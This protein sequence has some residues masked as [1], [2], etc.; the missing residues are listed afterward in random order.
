MH[1]FAF[2]RGINVG[3][4]KII[5]MERLREVLTELGLSDVQTYIQSGNVSFTTNQEDAAQLSTA[6]SEAIKKAFG[7]EVR[8]LLRTAE[9]LQLIVTQNP[10]ADRLIDK[11]HKL[12]VTFLPTEPTIDLQPLLLQPQVGVEA[13]AI[14]GR[15]VYIYWLRQPGKPLEAHSV[16]EK[17]LRTQATTRDWTVVLALVERFCH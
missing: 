8:I 13:C 3:G 14:K 2:L 5:K 10:F 4:N 7:F 16:L 15:E 1:F 6:I 17:T 9:E 11:D 12:Y